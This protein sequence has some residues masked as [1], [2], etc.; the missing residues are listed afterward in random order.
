MQKVYR[1]SFR[2]KPAPPKPALPKPVPG[3]KRVCLVGNNYIGT[4][5]ALAG[6]V[7]DVQNM[8]QQIATY[9]PSCKD[10][11]VLTDASKQ[12]ILDSLS[13]L[14]A[15]LRTGDNV[16]FQFSGHGGQLRDTNGDEVSGMDSCIYPVNKGQM[17]LLL[18]DELRTHLAM[19]IPAGCKCFIVLDCCHSGSGVD[20]R[21]TW[22]SPSFGSL[23]YTEAPKYAKTAGTVLFLSGCHDVQVAMDTVDK[24]GRP[25][26]ALT[27]ALLDVWRTY[28]PAI[29]LK[30]LLWDIRKYLKEHGYEQVPQL[31]TGTWMDMNA[32]FDLRN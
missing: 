22:Q 7:N 32:V 13:W 8:K 12:A 19:K 16:L 3:L 21:Y 28:G 29:K 24:T 26:G 27:M 14:T 11:R 20:L 2:P 1:F 17:E 23:T 25:S 10:V 6:C 9:F 18:D 30:Y 15:G 31:T 5:Y 4:P